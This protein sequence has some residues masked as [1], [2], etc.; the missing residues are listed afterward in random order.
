MDTDALPA[1]GQE[2]V[3]DSKEETKQEEGKDGEKEEGKEEGEKEREREG[4]K[5]KDEEKDDV[6]AIVLGVSNRVQVYIPKCVKK[7]SELMGVPMEYDTFIS[8]CEQVVAHL[9]ESMEKPKLSIST[10][11]STGSQTDFPSLNPSSPLSSLSCRRQGGA[12]NNGDEAGGAGPSRRMVQEEEEKTPPPLSPLGEGKKDCPLPLWKQEMPVYVDPKYTDELDVPRR[13][14]YVG[15]GSGMGMLAP[16]AKTNHKFKVDGVSFNCVFNAYVAQVWA[17]NPEDFKAKGKLRDTPEVFE[18]IFNPQGKAKDKV[19]GRKGEKGGAKSRGIIRYEQYTNTTSKSS[20]GLNTDDSDDQEEEGEDVDEEEEDNGDEEEEG[21]HN[22]DEEEEEK[23]GR[24]RTGKA[25]KDKYVHPMYN[26]I[27]VLARQVLNNYKKSYE[28]EPLGIVLNKEASTDEEEKVWRRMYKKA[29]LVDD[30]M[31]AALMHTGDNE[32]IFY[33]H[34][35]Y[36]RRTQHSRSDILGGVVL[37]EQS[38]LVGNNLIGKVLMDLRENEKL[39]ELHE[40][41]AAENEQEDRRIAKQVGVHMKLKAHFKKLKAAQ[42]AQLRKN[43]CSGGDASGGGGGLCFASSAVVAH[44]KSEHDLWEE[45]LR[46]MNEDAP[47]SVT[48]EMMQ[49]ILQEAKSR[50]EVKERQRKKAADARARAKAAKIL[51]QMKQTKQAEKQTKQAE[52]KEKQ[53]GKKR[54]RQEEEEEED[55]DD[56]VEIVVKK[57]KDEKKKE[58]KKKEE[59]KEEKKKKQKK[60]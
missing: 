27:G 3:D 60:E 43:G 4:E 54:A 39:V 1:E 12:G 31:R 7:E 47:G 13:W 51:K 41:W 57:K 45:R 34:G 19:E 8:V 55:D 53:A 23:G 46:K 26:Q 56:E 5:E 11:C 35:I 29:L 59:Q 52:K 28:K 50:D 15:V 38:A 42:N 17:A 24:R 25:K 6:A 18:L 48:P 2:K 33:I 10:T 44:H 32:I 9:Y 30:Q 20:K 40:A 37:G 49:S 14:F 36:V 58:E 16:T 21:G 22:E